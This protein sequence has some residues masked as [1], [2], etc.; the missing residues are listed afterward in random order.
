MQS[1]ICTF[2]LMVEELYGE[3]ISFYQFE[4][5]CS[6]LM[7]TVMALTNAVHISDSVGLYIFDD[8]Y[9]HSNIK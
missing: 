3:F 2:F 9:D 5:H 4:W 1:A 7:Y 6:M 8:I